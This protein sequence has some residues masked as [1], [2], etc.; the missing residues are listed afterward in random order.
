MAVKRGENADID[1]KT[2]PLKKDVPEHEK[3]E[4]IRNQFGRKPIGHSEASNENQ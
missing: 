1:H 2:E 3:K 4:I